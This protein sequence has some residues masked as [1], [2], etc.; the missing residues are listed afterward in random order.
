MCKFMDAIMSH[1]VHIHVYACKVVMQC[2]VNVQSSS[3]VGAFPPFPD[4]GVNM[5]TNKRPNIARQTP[6][7]LNHPFREKKKMSRS[8]LATD[9]DTRLQ[10]FRIDEKTAIYRWIRS[11]KYLFYPCQGWLITI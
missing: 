6:W 5:G 10:Q 7:N 1:C 11:S 2:V 9:H 3:G 8:V 4:V